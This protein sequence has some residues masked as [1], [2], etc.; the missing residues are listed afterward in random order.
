MKAWTITWGEQSWTDATATAGHV[1]A[2]A[3]MLEVGVGFDVSPWDGPKQ[4][5]GWIAVL[6][7]ASRVTADNVDDANRLVSDALIE[8]YSA[9]PAQ[10]L[11]ALSVRW[12]APS[13]V[14]ADEDDSDFVGV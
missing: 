7:A 13:G 5:A 14:A 8:V 12:P 3:D 4:L 11:G 9:T 1:I 6:L 10:L 2:V